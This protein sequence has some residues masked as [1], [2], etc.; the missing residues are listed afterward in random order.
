MKLAS[1]LPDFSDLVRAAADAA[2]LSA[3]VVDKDYYVVRALRAL[4][5]ELGGKFLFK[6][7]TSLSKGWN[8]IER[9]SEDID[10]LFRVDDGGAKL[11]KG[12][13]DKR[14]LRAQEIVRNTPGFTLDTYNWSKGERRTSSFVYPRSQRSLAPIGDKV[15]LEM[16][17]RGGTQ[18]YRARSIRSFVAEHAAAI[19]QAGLADDLTAFDIDCL[20]V[21]RTFVEKF[22]AAY[23]AY[24]R[25]RALGRTR[26]YYD[27]YRLAGLKEVRQ[28]I[29]GKDFLAVFADVRTFSEKH[30]PD[31]PVPPET[32]I[33]R[34][35]ALHPDAD[36]LAALIRNYADERALFFREPPMMGEILDRLQQL[37][38]PE[39]SGSSVK[40]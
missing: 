32:N 4:Q 34:C 7:G 13:I 11:S 9:F 37:P 1:D 24:S 31:H 20:D 2:R 8:L 3:D 17:C 27:L 19:G 15:L 6:G 35:D 38:F 25:D 10:L 39:R 30:W 36:G 26:H 18:P 33:G 21:T 5:S 16:G 29:A 40:L 28:F 14:L 22:F 12:Q 23:A